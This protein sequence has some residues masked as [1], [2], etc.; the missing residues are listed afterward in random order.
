MQTIASEISNSVNGITATQLKEN[1]T[2]TDVVV[3]L[4]KDDR[5]SEL[6]L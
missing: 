2:D 5:S 1:G 3:M 4:D 6:D